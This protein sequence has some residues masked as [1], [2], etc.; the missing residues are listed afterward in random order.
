MHDPSV[1]GATLG[2]LALELQRARAGVG[3][4]VDWPANAPPPVL[5][6]Y[7]TSEQLRGVA[8][9]SAQTVGYYDGRIHISID[10]ELTEALVDQTLVHEYVHFA[11]NSLGVPRPMWLHEGLAMQVAQETWW[12]SSRLDLVR[13]LKTDHLPFDAM[14]LAFPHTADEKFALAAY[15]QSY[16]MVGFIQAMRGPNATRE[17]VRRLSSLAT[18]DAEAFLVGAGLSPGALEAHWQRHVQEER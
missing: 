16:K 13:W 10:T 3:E 11:L 6:V 12:A 18:S 5:V 14:V 2:R 4:W 1:D 15:F 8:C 17:L 9:A 7:Q